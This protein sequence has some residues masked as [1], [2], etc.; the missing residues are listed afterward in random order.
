MILWS[1]NGNKFTNKLIQSFLKKHNVHWYSTYSK[2]KAVIVERFNLTLREWIDKYKTEC[3]LKQDQKFNLKEALEFIEYYNNQEHST[4]KISPND[5]HKEENE[6]EVRH[7]YI[8][9]Y[10]LK[11]DDTVKYNV[12]DLIRIYKYKDIFTKKSYIRFTVEVFIVKE[13]LETKPHSYLLEDLNGEKI[14]GSFYS[15]ELI[16]VANNK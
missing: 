16:S 10:K 14:K 2:L 7:R 9:K 13:V 8:V 15:F 1:N 6:K 11:H 3:E 12:G 5:A 4:V